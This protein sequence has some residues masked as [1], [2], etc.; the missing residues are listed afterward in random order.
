[1]FLHGETA[2]RFSA[3]AYF[4]HLKSLYIKHCC[5]CP[6]GYATRRHCSPRRQASQLDMTGGLGDV[7]GILTRTSYETSMNEHL[8]FHKKV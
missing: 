8:F 7:F 3:N 1:M 4:K 5:T 2:P 6:I